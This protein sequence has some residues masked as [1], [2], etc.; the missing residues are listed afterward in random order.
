MMP[1]IPEISTAF[2]CGQEEISSSVPISTAETSLQPF[3]EE[4]QHRRN[5]LVLDVSKLHM[6]NTEDRLTVPDTRRA[7]AATPMQIRREGAAQHRLVL[8]TCMVPELP[9][10]SSAGDTDDHRENVAV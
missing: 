7:Q 10:T 6:R 1:A 9:T 8:E 4:A 5:D 3:A 2:A